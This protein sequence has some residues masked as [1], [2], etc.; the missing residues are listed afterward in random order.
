[1]M[2]ASTP[3]YVSAERPHR[4]A[5]IYGAREVVGGGRAQ[6]RVPGRLIRFFRGESAFYRTLE[7]C[8]EL[9]RARLGWSV[10]STLAA[11]DFESNEFIEPCLTSVQIA[12]T[13]EWR[14]RGVVPDAIVGR[15]GGEFA[16]EYARG[17]LR[18]EDAIEVACR[19]SDL[20]KS[21]R[22]AGK[23]MWLK[24]RIRQVEPLLLSAPRKCWI[25]GDDGEGTLIVCEIETA[26]EV[27][28]FLTRSGM[29]HKVVR[30]ELGAHSP[31]VDCWKED[32]L[33]P[34]PET[35]AVANAPAYYSSS[36]VG[37][38]P[39][40]PYLPRLWRT[41]REPTLVSPAFRNAIDD[42]YDVFLE[43]GWL[44]RFK[45]F[46]APEAKAAGKVV[47][48]VSSVVAGKSLRRSLRRAERSLRKRGLVNAPPG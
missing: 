18:M 48:V 11:G 24:A 25:A 19:I 7:R 42:G 5:F 34:L 43:I 9:V 20:L 39:G 15:C 38:D 10:L 37:R 29:D 45:S 47:K 28:D 33:R 2:T 3:P 23:L 16:A 1:M 14:E 46:I 4:L 41:V 40:G 12:L 6:I 26:Q 44:P 21:G 31:L 13:D 36:A 35:A 32:L 22:G 30:I 27:S 8:D 17:T